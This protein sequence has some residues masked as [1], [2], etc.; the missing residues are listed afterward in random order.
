[1]K[2]AILI[3]LLVALFFTMA[4]SQVN[5]Q[6][7]RQM[8]RQ[9]SK[10]QRS[11]V[12]SF[13]K[14]RRTR[15]LHRRS[16]R[17]M[18]RLYGRLERDL[19]RKQFRQQRPQIIRVVRPRYIRRRPIRII[20]ERLPRRTGKRRAEAAIRSVNT[21]LG[22]VKRPKVVVRVQNKKPIINVHNKSL[23]TK[24]EIV[25]IKK[26]IDEMIRQSMPTMPKIKGSFSGDTIKVEGK[27]Y[28]KFLN[29]MKNRKFNFD[30]KEFTG[31]I[32]LYD[33]F[34]TK[35]QKAKKEHK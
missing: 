35:L 11:L 8:A 5:N 10:R 13:E 22:D 20:R 2:F 21:L 32:G 17:Q 24:K 18:R 28:T 19:E 26:V 9:L 14:E 23:N 12:R 25:D 16:R 30:E 6:K 34:M 31:R 33:G 29:K 1:M 3:L 15:R 27:R 4:Q 7:F